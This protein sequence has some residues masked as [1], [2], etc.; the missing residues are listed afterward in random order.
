[1]KKWILSHKK[2]AVAVA[3]VLAA[4]IIALG[5]FFYQ[6]NSASAS[7]TAD[8]AASTE[9]KEIDA[10]G[11]VKYT[12]ME[13][14]SIDFPSTVT[15]VLVKEGDRVTLGQPLITLDISEYNGNI[16][17]LKQQLAANQAALPTATQDVS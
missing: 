5:I 14:I 10:W 8:A 9:Q 2:S 11:E 1:M 12:H 16:K 3:C 13:D 7:H 15:D 6:K 17:K 4:L